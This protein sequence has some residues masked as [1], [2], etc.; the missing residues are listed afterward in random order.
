MSLNFTN[1]VS[2]I[3]SNV[4]SNSTSYPIAEKVIDI[5]VGVD[6]LLNIIFKSGGT[7]NFDDS[8]HTDYPIITTDLIKGQRDYS[9]TSDENGNLILDIY[10]VMVKDESGFFRELKPR[11]QQTESA[12]QG[13]WDGQDIEGA[14]VEYDK[15]ANGIF[16]NQIPSYNS[17]G[18][19]KIFI[20]REGSYF[21]TS[22]TTK[23]PGFAG[24]FHSYLALFPSYQ[25]A[26]RN[27]LSNVKLF[28][29][30][31]QKMEQEVSDFYGSRGKD[32][33]RVIRSKY[34]SPE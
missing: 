34:N 11:D 17:T 3:D 8:N 23:K 33:K 18:G 31:I 19:L 16:L 26:V 20:N 1:I 25:Y 13:F 6:R 21:T 10:K 5:N 28:E 7:W 12:T 27:G 32:V 24:L 22:D 29:Y 2:L 4:K 9:F 14:V 15:T 30:E